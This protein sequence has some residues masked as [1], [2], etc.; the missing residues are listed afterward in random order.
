[1]QLRRGSALSDSHT[2]TNASVGCGFLEVI[3][4]RYRF[5]RTRVFGQERKTFL[6]FFVSE[7]HTAKIVVEEANAENGTRLK[8]DAQLHFRISL[9]EPLHSSARYAKAAGKF[10]RCHP[11]RFTFKLDHVS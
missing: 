9:F 5:S 6:E 10:L 8:G 4:D 1:V 2:Y 3:V 7:C 11:P